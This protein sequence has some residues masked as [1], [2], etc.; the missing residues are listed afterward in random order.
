MGKP[1]THVY[2]DKKGNRSSIYYSIKEKYGTAAAESAYIDAMLYD[3]DILFS[4]GKEHFSSLSARTT[5]LKKTTKD[6]ISP[7]KILNKEVGDGPDESSVAWSALLLS[8]KDAR[9]KAHATS[10]PLSVEDSIKK[11]KERYG[12]N[13]STFD[14]SPTTEL[15][16]FNNYRKD[17]KNLWKKQRESG[18]IE[19]DFIDA[20]FKLRNE[21]PELEKRDYLRQYI[22]EAKAMAEAKI[23]SKDNVNIDEY[24]SSETI[25]QILAIL[26]SQVMSY[27]HK[28]EEEYGTV[29][30][31]LPEEELISPDVTYKDKSLGGRADIVLYSS[32]ANLMA[33]IDTKTKSIKTNE[34]YEKHYGFM[35]GEFSSLRNSEANR[36]ALQLN[37]YKAAAEASYNVKVVGLKVLPIVGDFKNKLGELPG[38]KTWNLTN[39]DVSAS[40]L[41]DIPKVEGIVNSVLNIKKSVGI[42]TRPINTVINEIFDEK[43]DTVTSSE[44][45]FINKQLTNIKT[46]ASGKKTWRNPYTQEEFEATD[47]DTL[48]ENMKESYAAYMQMKRNSANDLV[49]YFKDGVAPDDSIWS[50]PGYRE[51]AINI[52]RGI[53]PET[54]ELLTSLNHDEL[55]DIGEDIVIIRDIITNEIS[56]ISLAA[57]HD[58]SYYFHE[59]GDKKIRTTIYGKYITDETAKIKYGID[60]APSATMH[61]LSLLRLTIIAANLKAKNNEKFGKVEKILSVALLD[62]VSEYTYSSIESQLGILKE[63][64]K[65]IEKSDEDIPVELATIVNSKE[66]NS[67]K[68]YQQ[69]Y[70][71]QFFYIVGQQED[72]LKKL[73]KIGTSASKRAR[74]TIRD[75]M[76]K[77]DA[78][79][80]DSVAHHELEL[81]LENYV[82]QTFWAIW[83][84][85]G[86]TNPDDVYQDPDFKLVNRAYLSVKGVMIYDNPTYRAGVLNGIDTLNTTGDAHAQAL[87]RMISMHEQRARDEIV[88]FITEHNA[89]EEALM[90]K[91]AGADW[92]SRKKSIDIY[93]AVFGPMM[94]D[95]YEFAHDNV[96]MWMKF[97][98]PDDPR[99]IKE[100]SDY[101]RFFNKNVKAAAKI[102]FKNNISSMYPESQQ[103]NAIKKW[104]EGYIP[105]IKA[106]ATQAFA[107]TMSLR[108]G[109]NFSGKLFEKI[110]DAATK[111]AVTGKVGAVEPWSFTSMFLDQVDGTA[112]RGSIK[113]R[114]LLRI[115]EENSVLDD[116]RDI[117]MNPVAVLNLMMIEA[118]RK[119]HIEPLALAA[120]SIDAELAAKN[121]FP[122]VDSKALRDLMSNVAELRIH[123]RVKEENSRFAKV[124][125]L[126]KKSSAMIA[127]FGSLRQISTEGNTALAQTGASMFSM[128]F[129]KH[130][131]KRD[132]KYDPS[133]Y[134]WALSTTEKAFGY[135]LMVDFGLYN[136]SLGQFTSSDYIGT[137]KGAIMQTK[138]GFAAIHMI[139][140]N[141]VQNIVLAQMHKEGITED[142][143]K[144]NEKTGRYVYNEFLDKNRFYVYDPSLNIE[145]EASEPTSKE[146]INKWLFWKAHR[147]KM[148]KEGGI[149]DDKMTRPF[150]VDHLQ[151]MKHYAIKLFGAMDNSEAIGAEVSAIG[152]A[153][154]VFTKWLRQ[155]AD[156]WVGVKGA[157]FKEGKWG[158]LIDEDGNVVGYDFIEQELESYIDS[159]TGLWSDIKR[160]GGPLKAG[161]FKN[162]IDAA[163]DNRIENLSKLMGDLIMS[164]L[165]A[166]IAFGLRHLMAMLAEK[167][168]KKYEASKDIMK[169][170]FAKYLFGG[171]QLILEELSKGI[172]NALSDVFPLAAFGGLLENG[173]AAGLSMMYN[174]STKTVQAIFYAITGSFEKAGYATEK[175]FSSS[176]GYR[177]GKSIVQLLVNL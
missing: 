46:S 48:K 65:L 144:L 27:K 79:K 158:E 163:H 54:H 44:S 175:L 56:I 128:V 28:L 159:I 89:L 74:K 64:T 26:D 67:Y 23:T 47:E 14:V 141:A 132:T 123:N 1:C 124:V 91:S 150:T 5:K 135:Q 18:T 43:L 58:K 13:P 120:M 113:T 171:Q 59:E 112:G 137:R 36:T 12:I 127:F 15:S 140:R 22:E 125:D 63:I 170:K 98:D 42:S 41:K 69:D 50:Q 73:S 57:A 122:G 16:D 70:L 157:S 115:T 45:T 62:D 88:E 92:F 85:K 162:A 30:E 108:S 130:L 81:A 32:K 153:V 19:H 177:T 168:K 7:S 80:L 152:R 131:F 100:Q 4:E 109:A 143:Y 155:K 6:I 86:V 37:F 68:E 21:N 60:I 151:S 165:F 24:L 94:E 102:L 11:E 17:I 2:L 29:F 71:D 87:H 167:I 142:A 147:A 25:A 8:A 174:L 136:T 40:K 61:N 110:R 78:D 90:K 133:D 97:K 52:L 164:G 126:T 10:S 66:L 9:I 118:S 148:E 105:I 111:Q 134:K 138:H 161:S 82:K 116:N 149:K 77:Y 129:M 169:D 20:I 51:K 172:G 154:L 35:K 145:Q 31:I 83:H 39:I 72:P 96:A 101:I 119:Q 146:D 166:A 75:L 106:S 93:K 49:T 84:K 3:G 173:P 53:T 156:N 38:E 176:G 76:Y 103:A 107:E 104:E 34:S 95:G 160:F 121:L 139:L 99:L 55:S 114:K 117:E 33:I